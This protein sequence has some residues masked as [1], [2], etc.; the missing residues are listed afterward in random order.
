MSGGRGPLLIVGASGRA[1]AASARRAGFDP[2]VV[3]V[4]ADADTK[5]LAEARQCP[6]AAYPRGLLRYTR[7]PRHAPLMYTGGLENH[8]DLIARLCRSRALYGNGPEA[9]RLVRDPVALAAACRARGL[10]FA[11]ARC[12]AEGL[13]KTGRWLRKPRAGSGGVGIRVADTAD[14]TADASAVFQ[15]F[16]P[17]RRMSAVF[18]SRHR[19]CELVGVT[20]QLVGERWTH[21][22]PF[23]YAGSLGPVEPPP[24]LLRLGCAITDWADLRG[25]WG[26]DF[27]LRNGSPVPIEV[28]PRYPASVEVIE[29]ACGVALL[30]RHAGVF[31]ET[32]PRSLTRPRKCRAVGKAIYYAPHRL[33]VPAIGPW[34]EAVVYAA[35]VWRRP[36]FADV[37]EPGSVVEPGHPVLTILTEA[38]T[39]AECLARLKRQAAEL[40]RHFKHTPTAEADV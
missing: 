27:I 26:L 30:D 39:D 35:T 37:P 13:P 19:E 6:P 36:D 34:Q 40:D 17:G 20:E 28:N 1:A 14:V 31:E 11:E 12:P 22:R 10:P 16:V 21:A 9:L 25:I 29:L 18:V 23:G 7:G 32:R 8:P 4:F 5:R 33:T 15:R 3:D 24:G 38:G 2:V